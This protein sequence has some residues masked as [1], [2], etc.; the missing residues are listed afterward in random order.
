MDLEKKTAVVCGGTQGIGYAIAKLF[1]ANGCNLLLITHNE[2]K[3][4]KVQDEIIKSFSVKVEY[5]VADFNNSDEV[6]KVV[7]RFFKGSDI[8]IDILIN[9]VRGPMPAVL[10][11]SDITLLREVF[12]RHI[13][14]NHI[15]TNAVVENILSKKNTGRLINICDNTSIAPYPSLGLSAIRAAEISWALTLSLELAPLGITVNNILPGPTDTHGLEKIIKIIAKEQNVSYE[16][17]RNEI[18][19]TLPMK[20]LALPDEI[21]NVALFLASDKASYITGSNIKVDGGFNVSI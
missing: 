19:N 16:A 9:N 3:L 4:R 14:S 7:D 18:I 20:R 11:K 15:I 17:K 6:Q 1:A 12:E 13:I 8:T 10:F 2:N 5:L 21:A